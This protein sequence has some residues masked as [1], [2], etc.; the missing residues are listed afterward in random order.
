MVAPLFARPADVGV[1][2]V[3]EAQRTAVLPLVASVVSVVHAIHEGQP[4][5]AVERWG[6]V[7]AA[8]EVVAVD[9]GQ[10]PSTGGHIAEPSRATARRD[11]DTRAERICVEIYLDH[12]NIVRPT[13]GKP[14]TCFNTLPVR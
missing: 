1:I 4:F 8:A 7:R 3:I 11:D 6:G 2:V 5:A 13:Q 10:S 12:T 9:G 14:R